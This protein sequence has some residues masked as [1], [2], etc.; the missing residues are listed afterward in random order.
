MTYSITILYKDSCEPAPTPGAMDI[1]GEISMRGNQMTMLSANLP[2]I[3]M[4][5]P[6]PLGELK[7]DLLYNDTAPI[8][9]HQEL[10]HGY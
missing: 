1:E 2:A 8:E 3:I 7:F 4:V 9:L 10:C 5:R 6:S